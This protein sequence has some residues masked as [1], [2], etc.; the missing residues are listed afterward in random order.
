MMKQKLTWN[1]DNGVLYF[2]AKVSFSSLLHLSQDHGTDLLRRENLS[3]TILDLDLNVW[4]AILVHNLV[5]NKLPIL[6]NLF[7]RESAMTKNKARIKETVKYAKQD[8]QKLPEREC[9][10][11]R[12]INLLTSKTV[13][14]G[15]TA[16]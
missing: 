11:F 3:L 8:K 12:P 9:T 10:Y 6:L 7:V 15:L 13:L 4:L 2:L 5:R 16:A 1:S 14:S